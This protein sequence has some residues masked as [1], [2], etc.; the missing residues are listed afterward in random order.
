MLGDESIR[1]RLQLCSF[2]NDVADIGKSRRKWRCGRRRDIM[3]YR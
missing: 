3:I 2:G 1:Q